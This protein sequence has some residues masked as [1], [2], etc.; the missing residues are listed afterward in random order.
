MNR[1]STKG[2]LSFILIT[3][4][5]SM[6]LNAR[7][8][9]YTFR[10]QCKKATEIFIGRVVSIESSKS[11]IKNITEQ[12]IK[13]VTIHSWKGT[14]QDTITLTHTSSNFPDGR[15]KWIENKIFVIYTTNNEV[16]FCSGRTNI[17]VDNKDIRKLNLK[18]W[19]N[20]YSVN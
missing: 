18:Y 17:A 8:I 3:M 15:S 13:I 5:F 4:I 14:V 20:R 2:V 1:K 19:K 12:T 10:E 9:G 7:C 6:Q 11:E 16:N